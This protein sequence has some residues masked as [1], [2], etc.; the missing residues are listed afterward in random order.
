M[1]LNDLKEKWG[2]R[3]AGDV[4][5]S[6]SA[7]DSA[8]G[9]YESRQALTFEDND[10]LGY[11]RDRIPLT[12]DMTVLDVGCGAGDYSIA[13]ARRTGTV[14][15]V[16]FSPKM[17]A[18]ACRKAEKAGISNAEFLCRDRHHCSAEEF[19]GRYDL[20][21]AHTTPAVDDYGT[22]VKMME[23]S[24][25]YG[26]LCRPAR[27][28]DQVFD[29]IRQMAGLETGGQDDSVAYAFDTLW[30]HGYNPEVTYQDTVWRAEKT[31]EEAKTWYLGRLKGRCR[32][33]AETEARI[34]TWLEEISENGRVT[35]VTHTTLVTMFWEAGK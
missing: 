10:F 31:T 34:C 8:A 15:G 16:D 22:L 27:R 9:D 29:R 19:R 1:N 3:M 26:V 11:L 25:H 5:A 6:I 17:I 35:E 13:L 33:E 2:S 28:T 21:F 7:W 32:L 30:G 23:A 4:S 24:R 18:A 12:G 14:T 20:V